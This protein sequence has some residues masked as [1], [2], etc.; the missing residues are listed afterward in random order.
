M[1]VLDNENVISNA[2]ALDD[3]NSKALDAFGSQLLAPIQELMANTTVSIGAQS[4][5]YKSWLEGYGSYSNV[6]EW[7]VAFIA[8]K[9]AGAS[10]ALNSVIENVNTR[11]AAEQSDDLNTF[12]IG[13][14]KIVA[15]VKPIDY[16]E[17]LS[18]IVI[19]DDGTFASGSTLASFNS[20]LDSTIGSF[21]S[22][23]ADTV[24]DPL[25]TDT[26]ANFPN[27]SIV[28]LTDGN[29]TY[30][31]SDDSELI[32]TLENYDTVDG[33]GGNDKIIGGGAIDT[34][35][36]GEGNDHLYGFG[37]NDILNGGDGDDYIVAGLRTT[38]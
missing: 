25:G 27:A 10:V 4:Q 12:A 15:G 29:D 6:D 37:A 26:T 30:T 28:I 5:S 31:G 13:L 23:A 7:L 34:L 8:T 33:K 36:G 14:T 18:G 24:G 22:L 21:I 20:S 16:G 17:Y 1:T 2:T 3:I 9:K 38:R 11:I 32:A 19:N 35:T